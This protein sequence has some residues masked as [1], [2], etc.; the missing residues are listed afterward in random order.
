[1][2]YKPEDF[3]QK[4]DGSYEWTGRNP[5][6]MINEETLMASRATDVRQPQMFV[7]KDR[8]GKVYKVGG[9]TK[10]EAYEKLMAHLKP[11]AA[12]DDRVVRSQ[13]GPQ[14]PYGRTQEQVNEQGS[15]LLEPP[16][17][18]WKDSNNPLKWAAGQVGVS[19]KRA[20]AG[21]DLA[22]IAATGIAKVG[23]DAWTELPGIGNAIMDDVRAEIKRR[24]K[25]EV[26]EGINVHDEVMAAADRM[27]ERA[28]RWAPLMTPLTKESNAALMWAA[29]KLEALDQGMMDVSSWAGDDDPVA[30]TAYYIAMNGLMDMVPVGAAAGA[31]KHTLRAQVAKRS[32][33]VKDMA[34]K[35]GVKL[36]QAEFIDSLLGGFR[37]R[38]EFTYRA[39]N[40]PKLA[41]D[42]RAE[43][44]ASR[45]E[46]ERQKTAARAMGGAVKS[47]DVKTLAQSARELLTAKSMD[48][49][50]PGMKAVR[51]VLDDMEAIDK[52]SPLTGPRKKPGKPTNVVDQQ[53]A[54]GTRRVR[55][56]NNETPQ[57]IL[58]QALRK[59]LDEV[60]VKKAEEIAVSLNEINTFYDRITA[61]RRKSSKQDVVTPETNPNTALDTIEKQLDI[62]VAAKYADDMM[63]GSEGAIAAWKS[64]REFQRKH[65]KL[66]TAESAV[67]K[68]ARDGAVATEVRA[69]IVGASDTA[70]K[71]TAVRIIR[72]LK[73]ILGDSHPSI[74]GIR[75]DFLHEML[76]PLMH[77]DGPKLK[78]FM[79]NLDNHM[80][81][82]RDL[83][84]ELGFSDKDFKELRALGSVAEK[85]AAL[86]GRSGEG[87]LSAGFIGTAIARLTVGHQIAK[88]G[89]R[90][91]IARRV[92][93]VLLGADAVTQKQI[94]AMLADGVM[95]PVTGQFASTAQIRALQMGMMADLKGTAEMDRMRR[96]ELRER[97]AARR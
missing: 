21:L 57:L 84:K 25:G 67:E 7:F 12:Q 70:P 96:E 45:V 61:A 36:N 71:G 16:E 82:N 9:E 75:A 42:V 73:D 4:E 23:T 26:G 15:S 14:D 41:K 28:E 51:K 89:V 81:K 38:G 56:D 87:L 72:N 20:L 37:E 86:G 58:P 27:N 18:Q 34:E 60:E 50:A 32:A 40:M 22:R 59:E 2:A 63:G 3:V 74:K 55:V 83:M 76:R 44:T 62:A 90:V 46:R 31:A 29:P 95:G 35:Y 47:G 80:D 43:R 69:L 48:I 10:E 97:R 92:M 94:I 5:E 49:Y 17:E 91:G 30:S 6:Y 93:H 68:I 77:T 79:N 53:V 33:F 85:L 8:Q 54:G 66:F 65:A 1:M 24:Q 64:A 11:Q 13:A 19:G 39:K 78:Q 88:A 52:V